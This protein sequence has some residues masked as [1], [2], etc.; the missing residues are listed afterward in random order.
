MAWAADDAALAERQRLVGVWKGHAVE[1]TGEKPGGPV[2]LTVTITL[3]QI[4]A[5]QDDKKDL[6]AGSYKL[7]PAAQPKRLDGTYVRGQVPKGLYQG[8]Y[9][10]EGDTLKWCTA[11]PRGKEPPREFRTEKGIYLMILKRERST[12]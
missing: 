9:Q 3:E 8:I 2:K 7:N 1:G 6:G 4:S 5:V 11:L 12:K 10:L